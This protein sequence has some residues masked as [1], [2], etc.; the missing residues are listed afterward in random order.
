MWSENSL[1]FQIGGNHTDQKSNKAG[2]TA[3]NQS[4]KIHESLFSYKKG[5]WS[6]FA[7]MKIKV[8]QHF[9]NVGLIWSFDMLEVRK[10]ET[11]LGKE[12]TLLYWYSWLVYY[13]SL[14]QKCNF[15]FQ[16]IWYCSG[17][18]PGGQQQHRVKLTVWKFWKNTYEARNSFF[19]KYE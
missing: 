1:S 16:A 15:T 2:K 19:L 12:N 17:W 8:K 18:Q 11:N 13:V 14:P 10:I 6:N 4:K 7:G 9:E 5:I 3:S